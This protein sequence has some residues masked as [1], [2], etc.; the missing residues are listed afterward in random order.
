ME[1]NSDKNKDILTYGAGIR[2]PSGNGNR[3]IL[4]RETDVLT[5]RP[6]EHLNTEKHDGEE[7]ANSI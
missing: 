4:M 2:S 7:S 1:G 5:T 6:S 3:D